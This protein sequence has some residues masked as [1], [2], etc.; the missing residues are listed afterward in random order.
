[1][2]ISIQFSVDLPTT[3]VYNA[4]LTRKIAENS[5][6][7]G[8]IMSSWPKGKDTLGVG[9][10]FTTSFSHRNKTISRT[11]EITKL[12]P[13]ELILGKSRDRY[14]TIQSTTSLT[15]ESKSKT[16]VTVEFQIKFNSIWMI[17]TQVLIRP[18]KVFMDELIQ[19]I[20]QLIIFFTNKKVELKSKVTLLGMPIKFINRLSSI[21]LGI[22]I[23]LGVGFIIIQTKNTPS[24]SWKH[25]I[26]SR[27]FFGEE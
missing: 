3:E 4:M 14:C 6:P 8:A 9:D 17:P 23:G 25:R 19:N 1:M 11:T 27:Y 12:T 7:S 15:E 21:L 22:I 18:D 13:N 10:A 2:K 26:I 5:M 16:N 24:Y 20:S